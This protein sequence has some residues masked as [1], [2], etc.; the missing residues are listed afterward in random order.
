MNTLQE[1][2][3]SEINFKLFTFWDGGFYWKLGDHSNGHSAEGSAD[4][5]EAAV[6]QLANAAREKYPDF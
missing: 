5:I 1:L 2:Y 4:S 3:D 6:Q